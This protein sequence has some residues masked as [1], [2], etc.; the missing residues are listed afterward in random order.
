MG[1]SKKPFLVQQRLKN[2]N[3]PPFNLKGQGLTAQ[4]LAFERGVLIDAMV[5]HK[6]HPVPGRFFSCQ[7]E[8]HRPEI[9]KNTSFQ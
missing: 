2:S 9:E 6:T 4:V 7:S 8:L 3:A 1:L 5:R